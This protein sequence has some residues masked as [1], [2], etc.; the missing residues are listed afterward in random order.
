MVAR[1]LG[2]LPLRSLGWH[3]EPITLALDDQDGDV[4]GLELGKPALLRLVSAPRRRERKG[5][6]DDG[7]GR[8]AIHRSTGDARSERAAADDERQALEL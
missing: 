7:F 1:N 4:D 6:T 2:H 5:E 3:S 8:R